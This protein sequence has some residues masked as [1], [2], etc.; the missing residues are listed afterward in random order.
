[1]YQVE[2]LPPE[3]IP[4][5]SILQWFLMILTSSY[6]ISDLSSEALFTLSLLFFFINLLGCFVFQG[7]SVET[8]NKTNLKILMDWSKKT[9][10]F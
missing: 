8:K 2:I 7:F 10:M 4:F 1:V 6:D 5:G 3:L 9:F